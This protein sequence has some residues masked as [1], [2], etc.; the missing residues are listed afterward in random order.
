MISQFEPDTTRVE[1]RTVHRFQGNE[2]DIVIFDT[3]DAAPL[4]PGILLTD[5]SPYSTSNNLI[6]VSISRARGKL[7]IVSDLTYFMTEALD[8]TISKVLGEALTRGNYVNPQS[9]VTEDKD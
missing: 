7:V 6:N 2:R 9:I 4:R 8:S 3:V 5:R 1:C